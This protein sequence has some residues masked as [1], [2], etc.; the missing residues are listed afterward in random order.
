MRI[1]GFN[2][3][4]KMRNVKRIHNITASAYKERFGEEWDNKAHIDK[5][6]ELLKLNNTNPKALELGCG[7]GYHTDYLRRN[8]I[9]VDGLD[10]SKNFIKIAKKEFPL[11]TY[12]NINALSLMKHYNKE[13]VDGILG[14]YFFH[15][16]P[17]EKTEVLWKNLSTILKA[18]GLIL[19]IVT[20]GEENEEM[21]STSCLPAE[22]KRRLYMYNFPERKWKDLIANFGFN[23]LYWEEVT[24]VKKEIKATD[25]KFAFLIQ[26]N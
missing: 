16:I 15:F 25:K 9:D 1:N 4:K 12:K 8:G 13:S 19:G 5:F 11:S 3:T 22:D 21:L 10:F 7:W 20:V 24:N 6:I 18:G 14:I 17:K 2:S 23:V 26:K